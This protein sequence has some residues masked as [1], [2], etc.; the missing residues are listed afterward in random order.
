[1]L[2]SHVIRVIIADDHEVVL[3]GLKTM[4]S[5]HHR[6]LD[7]VGSAMNGHDAVNLAIWLRPDVAIMDIAM[8]SCDGLEATRRIRKEVPE[9]K[10]LVFS[11]RDHSS[12][13]LAA[14]HAGALG[15]VSKRSLRDV[16]MAAISVVAAGKRFIDP[17]LTDSTLQ[18]LLEDQPIGTVGSLTRR[19]R[20]VLLHVAWG[21]TNSDIGVELQIGTKTVES[22]R[23]RAC[24]KLGLAD[25]PAIVQFVLKSGWL[26]EDAG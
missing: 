23:A 26:D 4:I 8:P 18:R 22:Y 15:Y 6:D 19:E 25:R 9:T 14:L 13:V 20:E 12:M 16:L 5:R 2:P 7:C 17:R 24:E 21:F 11:M 10:V 3:A 1:M